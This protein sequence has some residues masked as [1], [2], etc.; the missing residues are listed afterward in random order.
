MGGS[1]LFTD[2]GGNMSG[3]ALPWPVVSADWLSANAGRK[4]IVV[5]EA[6]MKPVGP[7]TPEEREYADRQIPGTRVFDFETRICDTKSALPHMMPPPELFEAEVR[8][9]GVNRDSMVVAYDRRGIFSCARVWWMFRA[10]GHERVAV[11]DGGLP[12]WV[13]AGYPV[14]RAG[15]GQSLPGD[16]VARPVE[17]MF[18]GI[19]Q[20]AQALHDGRSAVLDARGEGRFCGREPEPRE[21]IRSG[22]MPGAM[23]LPYARIVEGGR[24]KTAAEI[25]GI[26]AA[27]VVS[28]RPM[29][30]TCGSGVTACILA[31]GATIAGYSRFAVYDGSWAEWGSDPSRPVD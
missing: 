5:L 29:I 26:F 15:N 23:N 25:R 8:A 10:M 2:A 13:A 21:G 28:D 19:D 3:K 16:F 6:S 7:P 1:E 9:L 14:E 18:C 31:L 11:L 22:H 24:I 30:F 20:V 27:S 4:D 17:G 12:A